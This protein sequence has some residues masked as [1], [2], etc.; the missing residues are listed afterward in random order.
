M[1]MPMMDVWVMR[2]LVSQR[3]VP[4]KMCVGLARWIAGLVRMLMV[5]VMGVPMLVL[6]RLVDMFVFVSFGN[7]QI[8]SHCHQKPG[9]Y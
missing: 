6:Q 8:Q 1:P 2:V 5:L 4:V 3:R 7:V 9:N